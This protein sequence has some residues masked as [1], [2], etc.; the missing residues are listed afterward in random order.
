MFLGIWNLINEIG[1]RWH[2]VVV[3]L[4]AVLVNPE[5]GVAVHQFSI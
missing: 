5:I 2:E 1:D 4:E 3:W